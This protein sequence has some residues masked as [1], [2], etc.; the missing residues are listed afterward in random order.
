MSSSCTLR[1]VEE[2]RCWYHCCCCV[3]EIERVKWSPCVLFTCS[4]LLKYHSWLLRSGSMMGFLHVKV[5][6]LACETGYGDIIYWFDFPGRK[7]SSCIEYNFRITIITGLLDRSI[8][9]VSFRGIIRF[10]TNLRTSRIMSQ[11]SETYEPP[12]GGAPT[13]VPSRPQGLGRIPINYLRLTSPTPR[14]RS[15]TSPRLGQPLD[16][17][18]HQR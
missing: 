9:R 15:L 6:F 3:R 11:F 7:I 10:Q 1:Q 13:S 2:E 5:G 12:T 16:A 8:H 18:G 14:E 4:K 17:A